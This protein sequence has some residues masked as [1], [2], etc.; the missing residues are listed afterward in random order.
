MNLYYNDDELFKNE[1]NGWRKYLDEDSFIDWYIIH[2]FTHNGLGWSS[3]F[4][5]YNPEY[6]KIFM[7]PLWNFDRAFGNTNTTQHLSKGLP[8]DGFYQKRLF[9]DEKF[10]E[11]FK[12]RWNECY[13]ELC[14]QFGLQGFLASLEES[15]KEDAELNFK[16]WPILGIYVEPYAEG[17]LDFLNNWITEGL[18]NCNNEVN[19]L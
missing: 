15:I 2:A 13:S 19:A 1:N 5:Y 17:E 3:N 7:G 9:L 6:K 10:V 16:I 12:A 4:L 8:M 11:K 18:I 14:A